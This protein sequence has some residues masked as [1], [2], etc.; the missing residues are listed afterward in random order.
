MIKMKHIYL[1]HW[2]REHW[3]LMLCFG[4]WCISITASCRPVP[5]WRFFLT[6]A[7]YF[8]WV[9][10]SPHSKAWELR[11][12]FVCV[13]VEHIGKGSRLEDLLD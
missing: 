6:D 2:V 11:L 9:N 13:F 8:R 4:A 5:L 10:D 12:G 1:S 3:N 7:L